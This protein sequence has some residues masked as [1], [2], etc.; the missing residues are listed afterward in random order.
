MVSNDLFAIA[1]LQPPSLPSPA[2]RGG[3]RGGVRSGFNTG[4]M[5]AGLKK[6]QQASPRDGGG[7]GVDEGMIIQNLMRQHSRVEHNR[8]FAGSV[9]DRGEG[10]N[11]AGFDPQQLPQGVRRSEREPSFGA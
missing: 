10:R 5:T 3:S 8:N 9:V 2:C 7:H 11:G 1:I 6:R 4:L